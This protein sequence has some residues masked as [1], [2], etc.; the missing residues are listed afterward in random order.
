[1]L[2]PCYLL[3]WERRKMK[4]TSVIEEGNKIE[5]P[6][7]IL[8]YLEINDIVVDKILLE[9]TKQGKIFIKKST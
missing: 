3:T 1:M 2:N 4:D 9:V 8:N 5:I 6:D 7:E